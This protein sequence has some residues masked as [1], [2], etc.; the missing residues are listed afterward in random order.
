MAVTVAP[1]VWAVLA[2]RAPTAIRMEVRGMPVVPVG[3]AVTVGSPV[4]V[5]EV[6]AAPAMAV[7]VVPVV[8]VVPAV[9]AST[10]AAPAVMAVPAAPAVTV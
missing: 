6:R 9:T 8:W 5:L 10:S 3:P 4:V 7:S 1:V 2:L